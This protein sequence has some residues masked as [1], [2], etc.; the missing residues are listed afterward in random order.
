M[1]LGEKSIVHPTEWIC[2]P[3]FGS[4]FPLQSFQ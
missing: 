3:P 4:R 2:A 1:K